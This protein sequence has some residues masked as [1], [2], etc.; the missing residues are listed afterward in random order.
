MYVIKADGTLVYNGAIDSI[1][2]AEVDDIAKAE[3]YVASALAAVAAGK[4]V[5]KATSQPYGCAVKY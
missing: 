4:P 3:N 1:R 5:A 2:S